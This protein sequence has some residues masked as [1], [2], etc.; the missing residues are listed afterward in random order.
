MRQILIE[1]KAIV[2]NGDE[3]TEVSNCMTFTDDDSII[4]YPD[5]PGYEKYLAK[6]AKA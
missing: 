2:V 6:I 5:N 1:D 3:I 4:I